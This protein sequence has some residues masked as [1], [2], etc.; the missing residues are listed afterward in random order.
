MRERPVL[1]FDGNCGFCRFWIER[2]RRETGDAVEYAPYQEKAAEFPEISVPEYEKAV[3]LI[4]PDGKVYSAAEA[5]FRTLALVGKDRW[6]KWFYEKIPVFRALSEGA[7]RLVANNRV[8]F[9]KVTHLV[10]REGREPS[11][12]FISRK[13]FLSIFGII[14]FIAFLSLGVQIK[15]LVGVDGILPAKQFLAAVRAHFG[16]VRYWLLPSLAWLNSSDVFLQFLCFGGAAMGLLIAL[17]LWPVLFL[18]LSWVFY[19][20]LLS[21]S[22]DFLSFQWDILLLEAGFLAIFLAPSGIWPVSQKSA[23]SKLA[24]FLLQWLLFRLTFSS[25]LI[26]LASGDPT[27]HNLTALTFHYETQPLPPW[28]AWYAHHWPRWFHI[29]SAAG[30]FFCEL[31][32]PFLMWGPRRVRLFAALSTV[33]LQTLILATGNYNFFNFLTIALCLFLIDDTAWASLCKLRHPEI[34]Q[35]VPKSESL[36]RLILIPF[37]L[38]IFLV[39]AGQLGRMAGILDEWPPLMKTLRRWEEP[40]RLVNS[41]GL[42]AVMT[43]ERPEIIVEGSDD[44]QN[45]LAYEFCYKPG[46]LKRSPVFVAPHQPRLDW[47]MWF[48]ALGN[49]RANPWFINFCIRL[50]QGKPDVLRL[51]A[52][53]PFPE[54]PPQFLR[55]VVYDY[56]FS[57]PATKRR[58]GV[59]WTRQEK[60]LYC[61]VMQLPQQR[62]Q[63]Q[64]G[65][66]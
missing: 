37:A 25:G 47:Q 4:M 7:Y 26:K 39:S 63:S 24:V 50:L 62:G 60:G 32:V 28:T 34:S 59:W 46:D 56:R 27:W 18:S 14:Y 53:N 44:G 13:F 16:P 15:A 33:G 49:Y 55:A 43:T 45:W 17:G 41:Y 61:P 12:Y 3:Q 2:W 64:K 30:M 5:V 40:F 35:T 29:L 9:S 11:E 22:R 42:F 65:Q 19:L 8:F 21:I 66:A 57:D 54:K 36:R 23:P 52:K 10:F 6:L 20:S 51:L 48:A 58:D 1:L 31:F 38:V